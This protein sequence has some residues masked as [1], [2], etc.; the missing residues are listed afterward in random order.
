MLV[1][2]LAFGRQ[3]VIQI[4]SPVEV[5]LHQGSALSLFLFAVVLDELS[6]SIQEAI[7]WCMLFAD[8]IV[9]VAEHK[10]DLNV[11]VEE[12]RAAL[13]CKGLRISRTKT[14]YLYCNFRWGH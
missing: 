6:K 1:P 7:L 5:E 4:S 10:Q 11:R 9:W 13:E 3:W 8:D 12:W 14:E 2:R